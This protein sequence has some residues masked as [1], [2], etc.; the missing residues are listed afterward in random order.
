VTPSPAK[1]YG[2]ILERFIF[3]KSYIEL[4][5]NKNF[6]DMQRRRDFGLKKE[7]T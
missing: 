4:Y 3:L 6:G 5:N 7:E 2:I 1:D